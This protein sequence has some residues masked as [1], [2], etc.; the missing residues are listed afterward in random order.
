MI[1]KFL[2]LENLKSGITTTAMATEGRSDFPVLASWQALHV[3]R[4]SHSRHLWRA[5]VA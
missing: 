2:A 5:V 3:W 4:P 1:A